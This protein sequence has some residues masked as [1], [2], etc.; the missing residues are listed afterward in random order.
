MTKMETRLIRARLQQKQLSSGSSDV[1]YDEYGNVI[2]SDNTV[3]PDTVDTSSS[4]SIQ[5]FFILVVQDL[6]S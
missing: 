5:Q 4:S 3:D 1:E 6:L 2:D